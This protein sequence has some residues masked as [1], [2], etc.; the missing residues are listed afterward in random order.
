[1][2]ILATRTRITGRLPFFQCRL[3]VSLDGLSPERQRLIHYRTNFGR[4]GGPFARMPEV[5]APMEFLELEP[6]LRGHEI[7]RKIAFTAKLIETVL[8]AAL[9]PE[10]T[11]RPVP[12]LFQA[13]E[14]RNDGMIFTRTDN[15]VGRYEWLAS[16]AEHVGTDELGLLLEQHQTT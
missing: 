3:F 16:L 14:E 10:M 1:M 15:L 13:P 9:Y 2:E 6:G 12:L 5:I 11:A 7:G 4:I 8:I